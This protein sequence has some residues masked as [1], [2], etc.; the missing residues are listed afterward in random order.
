MTGGSY[1]GL[2][3]RPTV[4][5]D[6][7]PDNPAWSQEIFGP[8]APVMI[9]DEIDEAID[10]INASEYGLSVGILTS[11]AYRAYARAPP[12]GSSAGRCTST[13]RPST[14]RW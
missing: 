2:Y 5:T 13:T 7:A 1:E 12:T 8:V 10:I 4:L 3:Y 6:F 11:D 14:T 9:Y